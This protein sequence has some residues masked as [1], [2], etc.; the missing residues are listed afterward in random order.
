[1]FL[2]MGVSGAG[3]YFF[4]ASMMIV[5]IFFVWFCIPETKGIPLEA[6]DRLFEIKPKSK[7]HGILLQELRGEFEAVREAK[8]MEAGEGN[9]EHVE[10]SKDVYI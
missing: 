2:A 10:N 9:A 1:M 8:T 3:V 6:M 5:S 4:F 7:A